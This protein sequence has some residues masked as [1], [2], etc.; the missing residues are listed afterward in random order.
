MGVRIGMTF[1]EMTK[2]NISPCNTGNG[3]H[4][5]TNDGW[6]RVVLCGQ[7]R[8]R[9]RPSAVSACDEAG[10]L[11]EKAAVPVLER[12]ATLWNEAA[13][14]VREGRSPALPSPPER[15]PHRHVPAR[16]GDAGNHLY[17]IRSPFK[18]GDRVL[19]E[20]Q[21]SDV[22][23]IC[24]LEFHVIEGYRVER[25]AL[26]D[27]T[28]WQLRRKVEDLRPAPTDARSD[29]RVGDRVRAK[30]QTTNVCGNLIG[31]NL[32]DG[33]VIATVVWDDGFTNSLRATSLRCA[34]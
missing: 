26:V 24:A 15:P 31:L 18:V 9:Q 10:L 20:A 32:V 11:S 4:L 21:G 5:V 27:F 2:R 25:W 1:E 34:L 12:I 7:G 14:K 6:S 19:T 28:N 17:E 16:Q 8:H 29:V 30:D 23:T 3:W 33:E 13:Q 22:G